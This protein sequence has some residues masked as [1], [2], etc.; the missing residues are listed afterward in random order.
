MQKWLRK[1]YLRFALNRKL[2]IIYKLTAANDVASAIFVLALTSLA[3]AT[4]AITCGALTKA[5]FALIKPNFGAAS[6]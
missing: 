3:T 4:L 6:V 5:T 1:K 2:I